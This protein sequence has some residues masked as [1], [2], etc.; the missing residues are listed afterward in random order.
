MSDY[1]ALLHGAG[2]TKLSM[3]KMANQLARRGYKVINL[4]YPSLRFPV[5]VLARIVRQ[6]IDQKYTHPEQQIHFVTHSLGGIL[7]RFLLKENPCPNLGRVVMLAPPN[8][9]SELVDKF[10]H[11]RVYRWLIGPIGSQLGTHP[12]SLANTLGPVDYPVGVIAG[13]LSFNPLFSALI[14][15]RDDG[16]VSVARTRLAGMTDFLVLPCIHPLMAFSSQ[17]IH[18]TAH[19]L[20]HGCFQR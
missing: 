8:Q 16:R 5:E 14:P 3:F 19:F 1:V 18:Q 12:N 9:G 4:G 6:K 2:Q 20:M 7:V 17:V 10:E 15:G 11:H 13:N